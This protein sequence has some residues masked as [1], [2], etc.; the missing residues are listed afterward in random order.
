MRFLSPRTGNGLSVVASAALAL[1]FALPMLVRCS[2]QGGRWT[3][4]P[5]VDLHS[6]TGDTRQ[7]AMMWEVSRVSLRDFGELPSWNPYHCGGVVHYLDPQVPFPG[8]L[9]FLLFFWLPSVVAIK[10][11]NV[12]HLLAGALG[13]RKLVKDHGA[14]LPEQLLAAALVLG[15]GA[16]AEHLGGGQLW[17]APFLLMPWVLWSYERALGDPRWAVLLAALFALAVT[18]GGVY[19]VPLM[20][21]ALA[22]DAL[23]RVRNAEERRGLAAAG[24]VFAVLFPLL[25]AVKLVPVL[26]FLSATPRLTPLD[27][28][29]TISEVL[30]AWTTRDHP[31]E[32]PGH[33]FVWPEYNAYVGVLPVLLLLAAAVAAVVQRG[34]QARRLRLRLWVIAGLVWCALGNIRGLSLYG[35]LHQLPVFRS[36]R[37][38]SRFLYPATVVAALLIVSMLVSLRRWAAQREIRPFLKNALVASELLLA[39]FVAIDLSVTTGPR[40]QQGEG[41]RVPGGRASADYR[42][43]EGVRYSDLPGFPVRGIGTSECYGGFDW[44][45]SGALWTVGPQERLEPANAGTVARLRW[46]PSSI[47]F[48]VGLSRPATLV[49]DQNFDR[50]WRASEGRSVSRDGLLALPLPAGEREVTLRHR[51]DGFGLGLAL[52]VIGLGLSAL[53]VWGLAPTRA[54]ALRSRLGGTL[55]DR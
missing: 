27:D 44:P 11:W 53:A 51:P 40:L 20:L 28:S 24:A 48:R 45:T 25:A 7:F 5:V 49:V 41:G 9:F 36:L 34:E 2:R 16:L 39:L 23:A 10:L 43:V 30:Q 22:L 21:T 14:N 12:A 35:A 29:M 17:F 3:C 31:R 33:V 19:P 55:R 1:V 37:V 38:P 26:R 32:F 46:S 15:C 42:L 47:A 50:G 54:S 4:E 8:P 52:T 13:A 6:D 18:E